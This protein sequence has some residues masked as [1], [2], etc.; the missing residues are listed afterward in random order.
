MPRQKKEYKNLN[1]K[2]EK[3]ISDRLEKFTEETGVSKTKAVERALKM[4][5]ESFD[6][7]GKV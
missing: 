2:I 3:E 4:Y 5:L 1:C 7:T 6:K